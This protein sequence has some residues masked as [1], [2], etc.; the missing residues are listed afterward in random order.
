MFLF[1]PLNCLMLT[2]IQAGSTACAFLFL[3][4]HLN[5]LFQT[6]C[7]AAP[8]QCSQHP[9]KNT[10]VRIPGPSSNI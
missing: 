2:D 10:F 6:K 3:K 1:V 5:L 8:L 4:R 9:F 7:I